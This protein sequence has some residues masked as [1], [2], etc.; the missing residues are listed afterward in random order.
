MFQL[1]FL[2]AALFLAIEG[3][4]AAF[5]PN[6]TRRKMADLQDVPIK[7]L[8][9]VGLFFVSVG[10]VLVGITDGILQIACLTIVLEG[11]LYGLFPV[12]MKRAMRR[13]SKASKAVIKIWGETALGIGAAGLA[14]F[15]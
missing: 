7:T 14:I 9:F 11:L 6:W 4:I 2:A 15:L 13:G 3:A 12:V 10:G 5:W 1:I 8:G